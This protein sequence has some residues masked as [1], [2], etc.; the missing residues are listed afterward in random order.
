MNCF[1]VALGIECGNEHYRKHVLRKSF[2]NKQALDACNILGKYGI[3]VGLNNIVG[4]P[5]ETKELIW[6]TI[7]LNQELFKVLNGRVDEIQ[8]NSYLFQPFYCNVI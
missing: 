7:S 8:V 2:S 4:F 1:K 5:F 6:D 3:R